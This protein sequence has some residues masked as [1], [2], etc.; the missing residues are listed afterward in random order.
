[1]Q[2]GIGGNFDGNTSVAIQSLS[3][4]A[5]ATSD[6]DGLHIHDNTFQYSGTGNGYYGIYINAQGTAID[7]ATVVIEN[8]TLTG[9]IW[10]GITT[11]RSDVTIQGNTITT[12]TSTTEGNNSGIRVV[13]FGNDTIDGVTIQRNT[14]GSDGTAG[15]GFGFALGFGAASTTETLTNI[16][17][18]E[19]KLVGDNEIGVDV[20]SSAGGLTI[21]GNDLSGF[22]SAGTAVTNNGGA[23][24][25]ASGNW[26]GVTTGTAFAGIVGGASGVD[27]GPFLVTGTDTATGT[28]TSTF[29]FQG[30]SSTLT[31]TTAGSQSGGTGRV[32][33]AIDIVDNTTKGTVQLESGTYTEDLSITR[34][35]VTLTSV[36]G[37]ATTI[38][39]GV[40]SDSQANF[41]T[42]QNA[43]NILI[44]ANNITID[45]LTL[46]TPN[47]AS[48]SYSALITLV[49]TG[50]SITN[51]SLVSLQGDPAPGGV[52]DS[53]TNILIQ[54]IAGANDPAG[55]IDGLTI[56]GNSFSSDAS[57]GGKGYYGVYLNQQGAVVGTLA[58]DEVQI[59]TNTFSGNI[60]RAISTERSNVDI[61][62]N[63]INPGSETLADWGGSGIAV[64]NFD[65]TTIDDV[66]INNNSIGGTGA[67]A[68]D[69]LLGYAS[70]DPL[71]NIVI[72]ANTGDISVTGDVTNTGV[73]DWDTN[74][75]LDL[76]AGVTLQSTGAALTLD[77]TGGVIAAGAANL[78]AAG[79]LTVNDAIAASGGTLT[80]NSS[81]GAVVLNGAV[82]SNGQLVDIDGQTGVTTSTIDST[83]T[84]DGANAGSVNINVN[85]IGDASL[86]AITATG[87]D[88]ATDATAAG[89][90]GTVNIA[91]ADGNVTTAGIDTSGGDFTADLG[92]TTNNG[93]NAGGITIDAS[94]GNDDSVT[95]NGQLVSSA[96]ATSDADSA[97]GTGAAIQVLA[98]DGVAVNANVTAGTN[99]SI[100]GDADNADDTGS[101]N[102]AIGGGVTLS[103]SGALSLDATTGG[104]SGA[105]A[106][107]LSA[108]GTVTINDAMTNTSGG[109]SITADDV[110]LN[111]MVNA[112]GQTVTVTDADGTGILIGNV[113][114]PLLG[115][116]NLSNAEL[117]SITATNLTLVSADTIY[118]NTVTDPVN[119]SGTVTV[120]AGVD[121]RVQGGA[122]T[123]SSG[124]DLQADDRVDISQNLSGGSVTL[125]GDADNDGVDV[126]DDVFFAGGVTVT[127]TAGTITASANGN[128]MLTGGA[129]TL[130]ATGGVTLNDSLTVGS[131][132][133]TGTITIDA[134]SDNTGGGT[135]VLSGTMSSAGGTTDGNISITADNLTNGGNIA[136]GTGSITITDSDGSGIELHEGT[137]GLDPGPG[138]NVSDTELV[139]MSAGG[140]VSFVT[141]G[142]IVVDGVLASDTDN[143]NLVTLDATG[144]ITFRDTNTQGSGG[145]FDSLSAQADDG[146]VV[147]AGVSTDEGALSLDGDANNAD[148]A[149]SDN[150]GLATGVTLSAS[151]ALSLDATTGGISGAGATT[152]SAGGTVTINDAMTNTSGGLSITADDVA[153][154]AM[155]N[156]T[157]QT[158][159]VTDADG[160]GVLLG[161]V[162]TPL[163]GGVN[164]AGTELANISAGAFTV[165]SAGNITVNGV[166]AADSDTLNLVTLDAT[167][168]ITFQTAAS[169]FD[170]LDAQADGN[171]LVS[172]AVSTDE[173]TLS[174][175][176]D[177]EVNGTGT[178]T[179]NA[180][181]A[182]N[183]ANLTLSA[184]DGIVSNGSGTINSSDATAA[185]SGGAVDID[186]TGVGNV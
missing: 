17:V 69:V 32:Q 83:G 177:D 102:I 113:T 138:I 57:A 77:A 15:N 98:Q 6:I 7:G 100:D 146:I 10:R 118:I 22:D 123:F 55:N 12:T 67:F 50:I 21:T 131:G 58:G 26:W 33:E 48:G 75:A 116:V 51:N 80:I 132:A 93:G 38:I 141:T 36:S 96:G 5:D 9:R 3:G 56:T 128:T 109:L 34:N 183:G 54:S 147:N 111:A 60:W 114:S 68:N 87:N 121:V 117:D 185:D 125:L 166:Q 72:A 155:V 79:N 16:T 2:T 82:S 24:L 168:S 156:A 107:T 41:P 103:A 169:T 104:I 172:V 49:G 124:L 91:T 152:L 110:A 23:V 142:N 181:L 179:L 90:G 95:I 120:D 150:I 42:Y 148:D 139:N 167:G 136:A 43:T 92:A 59:D 81:G 122:S 20:N 19:N 108:G 13:N 184:G 176:A 160:T 64:R 163:S 71:T 94:T 74:G 84:G 61:T 133:S 97:A 130:N 178:L 89:A 11:E 31:V 1:Q 28:A 106:T 105:G 45:D 29:G 52:N 14:V 143:L 63:T 182:S 164:L 153:L 127:A 158:V 157:G 101:D 8:N 115:G 30:D 180:A 159:T 173:G 170:S 47:V 99:V 39:Q 78:A 135:F 53:Q 144:S 134:D 18:S 73:L 161:D 46:K 65:A 35:N 149:G 154:N 186:F 40:S 112:T 175:S 126:S 86:G 76:A 62:N 4:A 70:S 174:L 25:N 66:L 162:S 119:I 88:S 129:L 165:A 137:L 37:K 44:D 27:F 140:G 151:G 145:A 171:I 85:G